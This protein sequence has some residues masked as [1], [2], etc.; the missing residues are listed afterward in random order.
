[1]NLNRPEPSQRKKTAAGVE[2]SYLGLKGLE[3]RQQLL[4]R[5]SYIL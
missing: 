3:I 4:L 2:T 5:L 1:M